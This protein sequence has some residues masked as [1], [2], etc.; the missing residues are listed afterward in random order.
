M[1]WVKLLGIALATALAVLIVV[2][3]VRQSNR[4]EELRKLTVYPTPES[5]PGNRASYYLAAAEVISPPPETLA[6]TTVGRDLIYWDSIGPI[7]QELI[8]DNSRALGVVRKAADLENCRMPLLYGDGPFSSFEFGTLQALSDVLFWATLDAAEKS[9]MSEACALGLLN[10]RMGRDVATVGSWYQADIGGHIYL[11]A[12][13]SL[14]AVL[15]QYPLDEDALDA[16]ELGLSSGQFPDEF[17]GDAMIANHLQWYRL[18]NYDTAPIFVRVIRALHLERLVDIRG[19]NLLGP[20]LAY[21]VMYDWNPLTSYAMP[22]AMPFN[23]FDSIEGFNSGV[24]LLQIGVAVRR[25]VNATGRFPASLDELFPNYLPEI[26][27]N[28]AGPPFEVSSTLETFEIVSPEVEMKTSRRALSF[29]LDRIRP[30]S[31]E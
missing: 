20:N 1:K 13:R 2:P 28:P 6:R 10:L 7:A 11:M 30:T 17:G 4:I 3:I 19:Y 22:D 15:T 18:A 14:A 26:P 5:E 29:S 24:A 12:S 23:V 27:E 21:H 8:A 16:L 25:C 31:S 9:N